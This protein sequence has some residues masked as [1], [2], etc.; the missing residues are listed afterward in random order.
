MVAITLV[1][2]TFVKMLVFIIIHLLEITNNQTVL[3]WIFKFFLVISEKL[4][5]IC[6]NTSNEIQIIMLVPFRYDEM[7]KHDAKQSGYITMEVEF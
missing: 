5:Y 3:T 6:Y 1:H 2:Y 4:F 7:L